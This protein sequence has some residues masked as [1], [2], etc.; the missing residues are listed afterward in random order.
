M[1][2]LLVRTVAVAS[3]LSSGLLSTRVPAESLEF[4]ETQIVVAQAN[5][6]DSQETERSVREA[7]EALERSGNATDEELRIY[8]QYLTRL[9]EIV[10]ENSR[11][12][13]LLLA[14]YRI[15]QP[16]E[17]FVT[18]ELTLPELAL[19]PPEGETEEERIARLD[20]NLDTSLSEFDGM[21]LREMEAITERRKQAQEEALGA[22]SGEPGRMAEG[23]TGRAA[24]ET[25]AGREGEA[26]GE[27]GAGGES[28]AGEASGSSGASEEGAGA[29]AGVEADAS[30]GSHPS[31]GGNQQVSSHPSSSYGGRG[32]HGGN[33]PP[34]IPDGSDDDIV[35]RQLREAAEN[36]SDPALR[37]RL[38][39]EYREYTGGSR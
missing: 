11:A 13:A 35:A 4:L 15:R 14:I 25:E 34:D 38:W 24:G 28:L 36:E 18:A 20:R 21:L 5:L 6:R 39:G 31:A 32:S 10:D 7:F 16:S 33:T 27:E 30:A 1:A 26:E 9:S 22:Q 2:S 29:I 37:E 19:T 12:L 23:Q 8:R 3:L 17:Q